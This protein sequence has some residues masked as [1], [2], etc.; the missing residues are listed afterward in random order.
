MNTVLR[1]R[2]GQTTS[3]TFDKLWGHFIVDCGGFWMKHSWDRGN[4]RNTET[5]KVGTYYK[6]GIFDSLKWVT[7]K[8]FLRHLNYVLK[9]LK[10][11]PGYKVKQPQ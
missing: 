6:G 2:H 1:K 9:G 3:F 11:K 7:K 10:E 4:K 8:E 5:F